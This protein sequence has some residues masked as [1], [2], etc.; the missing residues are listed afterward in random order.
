MSNSTSLTQTVDTVR[1][2]PSDLLVSPHVVSLFTSVLI[3][4]TIKLLEPLFPTPVVKLFEYVL[5]STY[6]VYDGVFYKKTDG[7]AMGSP[8]SSSVIDFFIEAFKNGALEVA[9]L[10]PV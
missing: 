3:E 2:G 10:K 8:L 7:I 1:L 9:P 6:F 4:P 5:R